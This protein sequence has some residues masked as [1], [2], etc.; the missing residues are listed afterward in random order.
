MKIAIA[1]DHAG[2]DMKLEIKA[3]LE[4]EG[5]EVVDFGHHS[6]DS[7][8]FPLYGKAA[9]ESVAKGETDCGVLICGTGI[10]ISLAA[11]KVKG[12][13]CAH[14]NDPLS[15][16]LTKQHNNANM[17]AFGARI[18]GIETAKAVVN[19]WLDAEFL[20]GKYQRRIDM[21]TAI[22]DGKEI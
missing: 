16:K 8:D 4:E 17:I 11:N 5:H 22:E 2:Y 15:A 6:A 1:N 9:A 3:M 7:C 12:I 14:C 18:I 13:R 20:G 10:G 21:L 19:E